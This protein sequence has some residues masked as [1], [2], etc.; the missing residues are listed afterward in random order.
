MKYLYSKPCSISDKNV[1]AL[2]EIWGQ[3]IRIIHFV[4]TGWVTYMY[5]LIVKHNI[6]KVIVVKFSRMQYL[7]KFNNKYS[8]SKLLKWRSCN[9]GWNKMVVLPFQGKDHEGLD[10]HHCK[11][12][13][14][15]FIFH[16]L[17]LLFKKVHN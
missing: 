2:F 15:N 6:G 17:F 16:P 7:L 14:I 3:F 12:N 5:I 1:K 11:K 9:K 4:R 10:G 13:I 8:V